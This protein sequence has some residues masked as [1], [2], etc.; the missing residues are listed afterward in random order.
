MFRS[1]DHVNSKD[2]ISAFEGPYAYGNY[3]DKNIKSTN[4][5][6]IRHLE[7]NCQQISNLLW[8]INLRENGNKRKGKSIKNNRMRTIME[9]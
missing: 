6:D 9:N 7:R 8:Q 5:N 1:K 3:N 2:K 4:I